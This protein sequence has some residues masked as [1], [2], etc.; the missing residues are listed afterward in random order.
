MSRSSELI[1]A[2]HRA[3]PKSGFAC[4]A[5]IGFGS[6]PLRPEIFRFKRPPCWLQPKAACDQSNKPVNLKDKRTG[7]LHIWRAGKR[8]PSP[9]ED[10]ASQGTKKSFRYWQSIGPIRFA[11]S[12]FDHHGRPRLHRPFK[13]ACVYTRRKRLDKM[14]S[15]EAI[16]FQRFSPNSSFS[17][18][19]ATSSSARR[20]VERGG[21]R[22]PDGRIDKLGG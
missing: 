22:T 3:R 6:F 2:T 14:Q 18:D 15:S 20:W 11:S 19:R 7:P 13:N 5:Q 4:S 21:E 16:I 10:S 9:N 8:A 1:S 17:P 12:L